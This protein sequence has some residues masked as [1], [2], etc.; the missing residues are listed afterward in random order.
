MITTGMLTNNR[1]PLINQNRSKAKILLVE[2][3]YVNR[4][5]IREYLELSGYDV[6]D[7]ESGKNFPEILKKFCPHLIL[8]DLRIPAPDGYTILRQMQNSY[9]WKHI[10]IIV[11][12]ALSQASVQQK[13]LE[14]GAR[15]FLVQPVSPHHLIVNINTELEVVANG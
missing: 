3:H 13:A 14:L 7:V 15:K 12:S 2:D 8:L 1:W 9:R 11:I 5:L 10:P 6:Y 4:T